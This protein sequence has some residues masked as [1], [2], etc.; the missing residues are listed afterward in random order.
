MTEQESSTCP[1]CS[2]TIV[3]GAA[4]C[5]HCQ[6][7][8]DP[9]LFSECP[10]CLEMI[11]KSAT[12]CRFCSGKLPLAELR[13]EWGASEHTRP[14]HPKAE[15]PDSSEPIMREG[16]LPKFYLPNLGKLFKHGKDQV[17]PSNAQP[18]YSAAVREQVFEV[19]VRQALAGAPWREICAGPMLLNNITPQE[20]EAEIKKRLSQDPL[21]ASQVDL[22]P[23]EQSL[24]KGDKQAKRLLRIADD[25][26]G[27]TSHNQRQN[28]ADELREITR[29]LRN[30][31]HII[32]EQN[33]SN[34]LA[35]TI[36]QNEL[37]GYGTKYDAILDLVNER[38][39]L[40]ADLKKKLDDES[41]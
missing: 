7:G 23:L 40:I 20:V 11:R 17:Q 22:T 31:L 24:E 33:D 5:R 34:T 35:G 12:V 19:I 32:K 14:E 13:S 1:H 16:G 25:L 3:K 37:D 29:Q 38:D 27:T 18:F 9:K 36:L 26:A 30:A 39:Q 2:E 4:L 21:D 8:L 41:I 15:P 6:R 10:K 28:L